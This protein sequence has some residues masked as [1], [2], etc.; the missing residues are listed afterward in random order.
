MRRAFQHLVVI[1]MMMV[2]VSVLAVLLLLT[3]LLAILLSILS[4]WSATIYTSILRVIIVLLCRE[5]ARLA[6][7]VVI[8]TISGN[9]TNDTAIAKATTASELRCSLNCHHC[10]DGSHHK[11]EDN[12]CTEHEKDMHAER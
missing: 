1:M 6:E 2:M 9:T 5:S 7:T 8:E 11:S 4:G 10:C 3:I 12:L